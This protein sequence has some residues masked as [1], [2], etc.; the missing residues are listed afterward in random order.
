MG[1][2]PEV[3]GPHFWNTIHI[4]AYGLDFHGSKDDMAK[5]ES[6]DRFAHFIKGVTKGLPCGECEHHFKQFQAKYPP[7]STTGGWKDPSFLRWTV[8]AHNAVNKR[9]G[10][11][12]PTEDEV[13][14]AYQSGRTFTQIAA[15]PPTT[16]P[17]SSG[18]TPWQVGFGFACLVVMVLLVIV[19]VQ[20]TRMKRLRR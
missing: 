17:P 18:E 14:K 13:V 8:R 9:T 4:A 10:K 5:M 15:D 20:A 12:T 7:P 2:T 11:Y 16:P 3:W 1:L 19:I 6:A